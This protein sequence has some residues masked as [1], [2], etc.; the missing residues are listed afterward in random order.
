MASIRFYNIDYYNFPHEK[1]E[2]GKE[3]FHRDYNTSVTRLFG[4]CLLFA[5]S[6]IISC[7]EK[8]EEM[9]PGNGPDA[10]F[11]YNNTG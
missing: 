9:I 8:E 1:D 11:P 2:H 7:S 5:V 3:F 4:D 6:F 10:P